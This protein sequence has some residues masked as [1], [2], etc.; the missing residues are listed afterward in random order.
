MNRKSQFFQEIFV[1]GHGLS[2]IPNKY[3]I[4]FE[5]EELQKKQKKQKIINKKFTDASPLHYNH[6][7]K[8]NY[9]KIDM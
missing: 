4:D 6:N 5:I 2:F 8:S 7:S 1:F 3:L 9:I